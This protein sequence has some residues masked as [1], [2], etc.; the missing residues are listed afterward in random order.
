MPN[1]TQA[2][3]PWK[4]GDKLTVWDIRD[5]KKG[6]IVAVEVTVR[7]DADKTPFVETARGRTGHVDIGSCGEFFTDEVEAFRA[8]WKRAVNDNA[9]AER[10]AL[11]RRRTLATL[12]KHSAYPASRATPA[13]K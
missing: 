5:Y 10:V 7:A 6:R 2:V 9:E 13:G 12:K 3:G 11:R 4:A 1:A 8:A